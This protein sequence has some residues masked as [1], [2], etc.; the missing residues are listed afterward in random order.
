MCHIFIN[1]YIIP[2]SNKN[3]KAVIASAILIMKKGVQEQ[4]KSL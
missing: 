4:E 3:I 2:S 1:L